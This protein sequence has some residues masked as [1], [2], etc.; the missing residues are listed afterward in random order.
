MERALSEQFDAPSP[1]AHT[2]RRYADLARTPLTDTLRDPGLPKA[3]LPD[4]WPGDRLRQLI[5]QV[6]ATF[7]Q[8]ADAHVGNVLARRDPH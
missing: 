6:H 2:L 4:D 3:L 1:S 5:D 7:G 8:A